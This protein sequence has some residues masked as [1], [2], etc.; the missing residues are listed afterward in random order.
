MEMFSHESHKVPVQPGKQKQVKTPGARFSQSPLTHG[1]DVAQ[2]SGS[3][4]IKQ[5]TAF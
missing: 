5:I 4:G 2:T 1:A 3:A